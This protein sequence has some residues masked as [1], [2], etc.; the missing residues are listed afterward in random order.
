M[1]ELL[2]GAFQKLVDR[3][4]LYYKQF[5]VDTVAFTG[6]VA[7]IFRAE[8]AQVLERSGFT[9]GTVVQYPIEGLIE[10]YSK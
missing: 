4:L 2:L 9:T 8:L 10:Y 3:N 1:Q 6:S 5:G 7:A